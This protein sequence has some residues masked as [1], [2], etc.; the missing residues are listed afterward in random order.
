MY[1]EEFDIKHFGPN[2]SN[3][4]Y[5]DE[6]MDEH[7]IKQTPFWYIGILQEI[8]PDCLSHVVTLVYRKFKEKNSVNLLCNLVV[9]IKRYIKIVES[10]DP[11]TVIPIERN[12]LMEFK[13]FT[14]RL[15]QIIDE[16][17]LAI[18]NPATQAA[19]KIDL[20]NKIMDILKEVKSKKEGF[21]DKRKPIQESVSPK[22][23]LKQSF[24]PSFKQRSPEKV[25]PEKESSESSSPTFYKPPAK[26][27]EEKGQNE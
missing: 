21:K 7:K 6:A 25:I 27:E 24:I 18:E 3:T 9:C 1:I 16:L 17:E 2:Y 8:N 20:F 12:I 4:R 19:F 15:K 22:L 23:G 11:E 13:E 5:L 14:L 10:I 26:I